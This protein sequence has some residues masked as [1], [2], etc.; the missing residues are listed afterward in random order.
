MRAALPRGVV[1]HALSARAQERG[2]EQ[3]DALRKIAHASTE[4]WIAEVLLP[5][6]A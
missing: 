3:R 6:R 1:Y 5:T 2:H 4:E